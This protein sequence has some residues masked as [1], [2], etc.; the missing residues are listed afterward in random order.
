MNTLLTQHKDSF[1]CV[2][3]YLFLGLSLFVYANLFKQQNQREILSSSLIGILLIA[4]A[5][6][7]FPINSFFS[8]ALFQII[9]AIFVAG[10]LATSIAVI[11]SLFEYN[12][13]AV[14]HAT[15]WFSTGYAVGNFM[16]DWIAEK[17][18]FFICINSLSMLPLMLSGFG[19]LTVLVAKIDKI[20]IKHNT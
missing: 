15:M 9:F 4:I 7:F 13:N 18:G 17:Y 2:F 5:P 3:F 10:F 14:F 16:S 19:C 11:Y 1:G 12:C 20:S 6:A 8:Y